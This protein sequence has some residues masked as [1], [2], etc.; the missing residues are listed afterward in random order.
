MDSAALKDTG[1]GAG[2]GADTDADTVDQSGVD[3]CSGESRPTTIA[4][5][6]R[7]AISTAL[8]EMVAK[9]AGSR[10]SVVIEII[11]SVEYE[12]LPLSH[13]FTNY[14]T[15]KRQ[16]NSKS[17]TVLEITTQRLLTLLRIV[18]ERST[19]SS[20]RKC[21]LFSHLQFGNP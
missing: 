13:R 14:D 15:I 9:G 8:D 17:S 19:S 21:C 11:N 16:L 20:T 4:A 5:D 3:P 12:A 1:T 6:L 7:K 18:T 2:A 10:R